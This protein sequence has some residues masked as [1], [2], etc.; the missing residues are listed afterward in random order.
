MLDKFGL[1]RVLEP[2]GAVPV[3]AWKIDNSR[4]ISPWEARVELEWIHVERDAFQQICSECSYDEQKM[5]V[6]V[7]DIIN[8]RGK[9]HNPF[10]DSGGHFNGTLEEMGSE[11]RR[12]HQTYKPG[13]KV[14]CN[15]TLTSIPIYIE[16]IQTMDYNYGALKVKGYAILFDASPMCMMPA[17]LAANYTM[18]MM[19]EAGSIYSINMLVKP[20]TRALVIGKDLISLMIYSGTIRKAV[21]RD[22]YLVALLDDE[23]LGTLSTADSERV[24]GKYV[25][26]IYM[27]DLT[28]PILAF[29]NIIKEKDELADLTINCE[30]L[31]G[32]EVLSVLMTKDKGDLYFASLRNSYGKAALVAEAMGKEINTYAFDQ[33]FEGYNDFTI[34]LLR[35]M[36]KDL[37]YVNMLYEKYAAEPKGLSKT[38]EE[39]NRNKTRHIDDYIFMSR[40]SKILVDDVLNVSGYDCNVILQGET[41]VGKEKILELIHKN[42]TRKGNPCI[43]I[44]CATIQETLA[45]SEF[46]GYEPGAFTGAQAGGK[47]GYF[48]MANNGILFLDEVG[49]LSP[50]LQS[51]LLRVLQENTFYR[52]GGTKQISVNVRVICADNVSLRKLVEEGRFRDDLYYRLNI[53]KLY[54]LPLRERTED[55]I[56]LAEA[57]LE[58]YCQRYG[59][60]KEITPGGYGRLQA[61]HWPGNVR[62]LENLIH[63]VVINTRGTVITGNDINSIINESIYDDLVLDL[64]KDFQQYDELNFNEIIDNQERKLIEYALK[65]AGTTRKAAQYLNMTQ[66]QLMRKKQKFDL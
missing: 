41:G 50:A 54:I 57:F 17:D 29:D 22:C 25:D 28:N 23:K 66:A 32:A 4:E 51:K 2:K 42:S 19:E 49:Q 46:F 59:I 8:K 24:L 6:K 40:Q 43:K 44:N 61:Y 12:S 15:C 27:V 65:K 62:E 35:D 53:C 5:I 30:D 52:L 37:D 26:K 11:Y 21:G 39:I 45:E 56:C 3:T 31:P 36:K 33:Y 64:K 60:V 34:A 63:R 55:I 14:L 1:S 7:I 13:D 58:R 38:M 20:K 10:T 48:E 47:K 18:A 9:L 16:E